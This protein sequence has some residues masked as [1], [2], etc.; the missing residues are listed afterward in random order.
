MSHG[1]DELLTL[2]VLAMI[3]DRP[4]GATRPRLPFAGR[5]PLATVVNLTP[6]NWLSPVTAAAGTKS[7]GREAGTVRGVVLVTIDTGLGSVVTIW[8]RGILGTT[9]TSLVDTVRPVALR[10]S[11]DT[12]GGLAGGAMKRTMDPPADKDDRAGSMPG[13]ETPDDCLR[14]GTVLVLDTMSFGV[15]GLLVVDC[16]LV[17]AVL[18]SRVGVLGLLPSR[19]ISNRMASYKSFSAP[20]DAALFASFSI[21]A[22]SEP[23]VLAPAVAV[24]CSDDLDLDDSDPAR[25]TPPDALLLTT[26]LTDLAPPPLLPALPEATD[27]VTLPPTTLLLDSELLT[28]CLSRTD[29]DIIIGL[30]SGPRLVASDND[31][32]RIDGRPTLPTGTDG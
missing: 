30:P 8:S 20:P 31:L 4:A 5:T 1:E 22:D 10:R 9:N 3:E 32:L 19:I 27:T 25:L 11:D 26:L 29:G 2:L 14:T 13:V 23:L 12:D 7:T 17:L 21:T 16:E 18:R 6:V 15:S 28:G 24:D